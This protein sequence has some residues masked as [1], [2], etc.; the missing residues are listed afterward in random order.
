M[1]RAA[2]SQPA[3]RTLR[4]DQ[5]LEAYIA[6]LAELM[7]SGGNA[8]SI[9]PLTESFRVA[10]AARGSTVQR[11]LSAS[12]ARAQIADP[13]LAGLARQEQD[14]A[15]RIATLTDFLSQA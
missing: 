12:A 1:T 6:L 3:Y 5:I 15:E 2:G 14:A 7:S 10:D 11:A 4:R 13:E 9:D 8:G